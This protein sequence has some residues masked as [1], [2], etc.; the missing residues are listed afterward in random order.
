MHSGK[1]QLHS[2][3]PSPSATLGEE[4]PGYLFTG[5]ASSPRA[6]NRALGEGFPES[7]LALRDELTPL[8]SR[9]RRF[10]LS[11]F[12]IFLPRVQHSGKTPSFPSAAAQALGEETLFP[13]RRNSDTR[14][15]NPLPR[16]PR[17]SPGTRGR[18]PLP[19]VP[20]PK[21]SGKPIF[22]FF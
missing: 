14:G 19:R 1:A 4:G 16:A 8:V 22:L 2:E 12:K 20:Q 13:E 21:H 17:R 15:R 18:N 11:L 5:K 7:R 10:L 3:K 9:R 6:E